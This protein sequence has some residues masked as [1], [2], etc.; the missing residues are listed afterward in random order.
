MNA[1]TPGIALG[2]I[3]LLIVDDQP[4]VRKA[5]RMRLAAEDDLLVVGEASDGEA[6]LEQAVS[7]CPDVV[8]MDVEMSHMDGIAATCALRKLC[9]Q[10]S[11]VMLSIH[12]DPLTQARAR[13]AGAA[14]FVAKSMPPD[15]LLA[16]IRR[17]SH[18]S[19]PSLAGRQ[20]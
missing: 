12:D 4:S 6:A 17:V 3:R 16:A 13:D 19:G 1:I 5:I 8:P 14:A 18:S 7:L 10:I 20:Q 2:M 9:P 11:V 15:A